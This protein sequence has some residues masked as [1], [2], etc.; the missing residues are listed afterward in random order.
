MKNDFNNAEWRFFV[1][2]LKEEA[3]DVLW[4]VGSTADPETLVKSVMQDLQDLAPRPEDIETRTQ[5]EVW[6]QVRSR[7]LKAAYE[8][9]Q[10]C[11]KCGECCVKGSPTLEIEDMRLFES[12][13]LGPKDVYTIRKGE[14][15]FD[16]VHEQ[17]LINDVERIKIR[18]TDA[19]KS[20]IFYQK[21]NRECSIYDDRPVQC[22]AQECWNPNRQDFSGEGRPLNRKD[23]FE[24]T[25]E[26]WK[27]IQKHEDECSQ[28]IFSREIARLGATK[29]QTVQKIIELLSWD[30]HVREFIRE[31]IRVGPEV[32]D[33]FFGRPLKDFL[34]YFGLT[35]D[36]NNDETFTLRPLTN[37]EL[38]KKLIIPSKN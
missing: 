37:L 22:R 7:L 23:L 8:T 19:E 16:N 24:S 25:G 28:E 2:A 6:V 27:V 35:V 32:L 3:R 30:D 4:K 1:T 33:L 13:R 11:I 34:E 31:K 26:I 14:I 36:Q 10:Y 17:S 18:E 20:C 5:E 21:G 38:E 15:V 29:G 12:G 9:R